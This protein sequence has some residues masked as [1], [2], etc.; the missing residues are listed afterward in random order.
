MSI[1]THTIPR[2]SCEIVN[3]NFKYSDW[4]TFRVIRDVKHTLDFLITNEKNCFK[5]CQIYQID[6][7][8]ETLDRRMKDDI[9][10]HVLNRQRFRQLQRLM[11]NINLYVQIYKVVD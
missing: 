1:K 4:T 9:D 3:V 6:Q 5:F 8:Q 10:K 7:S 11:R 2:C